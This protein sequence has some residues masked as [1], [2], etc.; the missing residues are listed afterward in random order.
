MV[1]MVYDDADRRTQLALPGGIEINY[2]YDSVDRLTTVSYERGATVLGNLAY[3]YNADSLRVGVTGTWARVAMPAAISAASYDLGNRVTNWDGV[4]FGYDLNGNALGDG[5]RTYTWNA[6]NQLSG[7][8]AA[9]FEYD[10]FGRRSGTTIGG[11]TTSYLYD[12]ANVVQERVAGTPVAMLLNGSH[13]DEVFARVEASGVSTVLSDVLSSTVALTDAAG[14]VS[15]E[16]TYTPHGQ[17]T[18]TGASTSSQRAFTGRD[19][20][21]SSG[22]FYYR[23]RFYSPQQSRFVSRDPLGF[24][25]GDTNLYAYVSGDPVNNSD[26]M[27]LLLYKCF[28]TT[29]AGVFNH[30]YMWNDQ[31]S[32]YPPDCGRGD[33][34]DQGGTEIGPGKFK[35]ACIP[36]PGS[37]GHEE[38]ALD[39]CRKKMGDTGSWRPYGNDCHDTVDRCLKREGLPTP[40]GPGRTGSTACL[41]GNP[42]NNCGPW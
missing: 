1:A 29:A 23:A 32:P 11:V 19:W 35:D 38:R 14:A 2:G 40:E 3:V 4:T 18:V 13:V 34:N 42:Y 9:S 24:R 6:R 41:P 30:A 12:D 15:T 8:G 20:D 33:R 26:P 22:L 28:R 10:A 39:C 31:P 27:G 5:V 25:A 36:I 7:A 21:G 37:A 16:Y 17:P